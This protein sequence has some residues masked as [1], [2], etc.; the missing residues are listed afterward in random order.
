MPP[1]APDPTLRE[2]QE[3]LAAARGDVQAFERLV[4]TYQKPLVNFF[5]RSGVSSDAEDCAQR[6]FLRIWN[7]RHRYRPTAKFSTF[8]WMV[9]RQVFLDEVRHRSRK[10][11]L[12]KAFGKEQPG[13]TVP[14]H[15]TGPDVA[16]AVAC[17]P[18]ALRQTVL[19]AFMQ[20]L[21]YEAIARELDVPL[22]TVKSRIF[23]A[24][25]RMRKF[26]EEE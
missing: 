23:H 9:A 12:H 21:K 2:Q 7:Y 19:M 25:R 16:S 4:A 8:L 5:V 17:L 24:L 15:E 20:G 1:D 3:M 6:T 22:G 18:K 11:R 10:E 26:L 14:N 13:E